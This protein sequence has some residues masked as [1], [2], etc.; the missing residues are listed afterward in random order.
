MPIELKNVS[1]VY[2]PGTPM[3]S[4]ALQDVNLT[5]NEGEFLGIAGTT[6]SGKSTLI[7]HLNGLLKPTSGDVMVD[8]V[9]IHSKKEKKQLK[10]LRMKVGVVF[11]YPEY[12]L[13]EETVEADI[14]F[15][16]KN[17]GLPEPEIKKR[18]KEA[19]QLMQLDY[20]KMAKQSPF[21]LSGGQKRKVAIAGILAMKPKYL[22]F[23]EPTAGLDPMGKKEFLQLI[24]RLHKNGQTIIMVSHNMDDLA[25]YAQRMLVLEKGR[26]IMDDSPS[27]IFQQPEELHRVGL[28]VPSLTELMIQL[29][30]NGLDVRTDLH[31]I[32]DIKREIQRALTEREKNHAK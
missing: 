29:R 3:E 15:G 8:G 10:A 27:R 21:E 23:D 17:L 26:I 31:Q 2:Q 12:Q 1:Y 22:V 18:V 16:P 5:I 14:G 32:E 19:M 25:Q 28:G 13:F 9:D 6:G 20:K 24:Q 11:Q 4:R 30:E 7:Q